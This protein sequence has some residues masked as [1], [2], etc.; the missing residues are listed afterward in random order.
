MLS[1]LRPAYRPLYAA[2]WNDD[3]H[4]VWHV[5]LSGERDGYYAD[6]ADRP[7]ERLGRALAEGFVYQGDHS[8]LREGPRG[9][10]SAH[11]PPAC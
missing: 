3:T 1:A 9:E 7:I 2:Q 11:L 5:A 8:A 6:Y 4:H 10:P